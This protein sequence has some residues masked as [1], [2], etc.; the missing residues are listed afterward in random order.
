M[1]NFTP[2][3]TGKKGIRVRLHFFKVVTKPSSSHRQGLSSSSFLNPCELESERVTAIRPGRVMVARC[4][5]ELELE[6]QQQ[7]AS[8]IAVQPEGRML[9]GEA[10]WSTTFVVEAVPSGAAAK[11]T[12]ESPKKK[13]IGE[14]S[15]NIFPSVNRV[16]DESSG[17][18][19]DNN[20]PSSSS[21]DAVEV[22]ITESPK[23]PGR[24]S[25]RGRYSTPTMP[26]GKDYCQIIET[27]TTTTSSSN[28]T[29]FSSNAIASGRTDT[30]EED[31]NTTVHRS[32]WSK[33]GEALKS[34][35][36]AIIPMAVKTPTCCA[37]DNC[38]VGSRRR[39]SSS[40]SR[41]IAA[42]EVTEE[43]PKRSQSFKG[44]Y[45][46][47][48]TPPPTPKMMVDHEE[49][50]F[51]GTTSSSNHHHS[52]S[53]VASV[54]TENEDGSTIRSSWLEQENGEEE[55]DDDVT[56]DS[57]RTSTS[58]RSSFYVGQIC[59]ASE[60]PVIH[61]IVNPMRGTSKVSINVTNKMVYVDHDTAL[62]S[63]DEIC[64]ALNS[65]GFNSRVE[66][67][68]FTQQQRSGVAAY[69]TSI[70]CLENTS[71]AKMEDKVATLLHSLDRAFLQTFEVEVGSYETITTTI[72]HN[73]FFLSAD[74][75]LEMLQEK[76]GLCG[77]VE[78]DGALQQQAW[79]TPDI[80]EDETVEQ[81]TVGIIRPT[82]ILSGVFWMISMLS[83]IGGNW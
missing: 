78:R 33:S 38:S 1:R 37:N 75:V 7:D 24:H 56:I 81:S 16:V 28:T 59:C 32:S 39:R 18:A 9:A 25:F 52:F 27:T 10:P 82:V 4:I 8:V 20:W 17:V 72:V 42:G 44:M 68:A 41:N 30:K 63:A 62:V 29:S 19:T 66:S 47:S 34:S 15:C 6:Q 3:T 14:A 11:A 48:S 83:F 80:A 60:I 70:L 2:A 36:T 21:I 57:I 61:S 5:S 67:D 76:T 54:L 13:S 73:P 45:S 77:R 43:W 40:S 50:G 35:S 46:I 31:E 69:V 23:R 51:L 74:S 79:N 53:D 26:F 12:D 49:N 55:Y 58:G 22:V 65:E 71:P 64:D